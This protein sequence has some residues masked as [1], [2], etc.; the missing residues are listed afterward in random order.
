MFGYIVRR[1]IAALLVVVLTSM[2]VFALFFY[3]PSDPAS[4]LCGQVGQCTQERRET[5]ERGL[6]L[7]QS[8]VTQ[9]GQWAKGLVAGREIDMGT[10]YDCAAPCLGVS[11]TSKL[12][13]RK[14]LVDKL[15]ATVSIALGAATLYFLI[16]L[17]VGSIAAK[18]RGTFADRGLV[19]GSLLLSSVPYYLFA[20]LAWLYLI[21]KW[22]IF[23]DTGYTPLTENPVAWA[24]GL[25]LV[26]LV[27]S[28]RFVD[29]AR[30]SRG[31]MVETLNEDFIRTA[32]AKG[33]SRNKAVFKHGLRASV[34]PV[35]TILGLDMAAL[36]AGTI[37]TEQIFEI[38]GIGKMGLDAI[39]GIKDF[40]TISA[41]VLFSAVLVVM[42]N[43]VVDVIYTFLDPRVR[44]T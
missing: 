32:S 35:V 15:P 12:E 24:S 39:T 30:F 6:G 22:S 36:M 25:L 28:V 38:D 1:I 14:Q 11:Y 44:L 21:N 41:V 34:V 8:G 17:T 10:T 13:V 42:A 3:G 20:L 33:L 4:A 23:P 7:D 9:Y 26:W 18:H 40:P 27:M 2:I 43:L 5:I 37:V 31:S 16:G 19:A 29:Y